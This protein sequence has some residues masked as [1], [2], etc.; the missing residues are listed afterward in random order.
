LQ[1]QFV[2][3]EQRRFRGKSARRAIEGYLWKWIGW[4]F[5]EMNALNF[6]VWTWTIFKINKRINN[7]KVEMSSSQRGLSKVIQLKQYLLSSHSPD[8]PTIWHYS[9]LTCSI[10]K[11]LFT[12]FFLALFYVLGNENEQ[13]L[14]YKQKNNGQMVVLYR[15]TAM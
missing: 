14:V 6:Q 11:Y 9:N 5:T 10:Y 4:D 8:T 3:E 1:E 7:Y 15:K 12:L 13:Y 2:N